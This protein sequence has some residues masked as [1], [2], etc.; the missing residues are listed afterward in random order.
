MSDFDFDWTGEDPAFLVTDELYQFEQVSSNEYHLIVPDQAPFFWESITVERWNTLTSAYDVLVKGVD[1]TPGHLFIQATQ[2]TAQALYGSFVLANKNLSG[3]LRLRYQKL[4]GSWSLDINKINEILSNKVV[5]PRH[6][7]W[8]QVAGYPEQFPVIPH[9]HIDEEDMTSMSDVADSI[10]RLAD[11]VEDLVNNEGKMKTETIT[12]TEPDVLITATGFKT[13][14][15][16]FVG[17]LTLQRIN[18]GLDEAQSSGDPLKVDVLM[19]GNSIINNVGGV[20]IANGS[21]TS[22]VSAFLITAIPY[23]AKLDIHITETGSNDAKGL[24]AYLTSLIQSNV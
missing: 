22:V 19:N 3:V 4:G 15:H 23:G 13:S 21:L 5:N 14:W 17:N 1:Y 20:E 8:E 12:V 16:N 10:N 7:S 6:T 11:A 24:K 9:V 2:Q 18:L